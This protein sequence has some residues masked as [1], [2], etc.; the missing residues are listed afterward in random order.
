MYADDLAGQ[1]VVIADDLID[2][3][4]T[5]I[6]LAK[7]LKVKG[8]GKVI[9]YG[10]HGIF[11]KGTKPLFEGGIDEVYSTNSFYDVWPSG[12][13]NVTTLDLE[14]HFIVK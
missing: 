14:K 8:A 1:D 4:M 13:D 3:G 7:A 11:S 12:V 10:T 2:G 6:L 9:L 5:F